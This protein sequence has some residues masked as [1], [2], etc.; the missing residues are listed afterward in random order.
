MIRAV[1]V[2]F[3]AVALGALCGCQQ[4][5]IEENKRQVAVL[6]GQI[7]EMQK[8]IVALK[9]QQSYPVATLAPGTCDKVVMD[10]ATRRG[11]DAFVSGDLRRARGYYEDAVT[12]CPASARAQVNLARVYERMGERPEARA[13]YRSAASSGDSDTMAVKDARAALSRLGVSK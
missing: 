7:K 4:A 5:A 1:Q 13:H 2:V 12:A 9:T 10:T 3:V 8:Q 6:E 11:S